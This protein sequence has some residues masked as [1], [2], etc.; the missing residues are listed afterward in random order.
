MEFIS[1]GLLSSYKQ[2]QIPIKPDDSYLRH[3]FGKRAASDIIIPTPNFG[4]D[5]FATSAVLDGNRVPKQNET[6][7]DVA[8]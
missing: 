1:K 2:D 4:N 7:P 8:P 3:C 5:I 6:V